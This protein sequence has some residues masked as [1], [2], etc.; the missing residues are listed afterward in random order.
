MGDHER[1]RKG[2]RMSKYIYQS[3]KECSRAL[4]L[5]MEQTD[6][7]SETHNVLETAIGYLLT[8]QMKCDDRQ[9]KIDTDNER[10]EEYNELYAE[11]EE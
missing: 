6:K 11:S 1:F 5:I 10:W 3:P 7:E 9:K 8:L 4:Q 2:E